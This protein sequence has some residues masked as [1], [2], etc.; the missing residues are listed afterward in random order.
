MFSECWEV[1]LASERW[2]GRVGSGGEG[3]G[4]SPGG[5]C[6]LG[7]GATAA[8][9][10]RLWLSQAGWSER[11]RAGPGLLGAPRSMRPG[12]GGAG[13]PHADSAGA[14]PQLGPGSPSRMCLEKGKDL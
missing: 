9:V 1:S 4:V 8:P 3:V 6:A 14:L 12:P 2:A 13:Q 5:W 7:A 10:L 11:V